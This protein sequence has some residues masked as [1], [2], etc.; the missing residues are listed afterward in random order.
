MSLGESHQEI[1]G[2]VRIGTSE[3][4]GAHYLAKRLPAMVAAYPDLEVEL[5][6]LPRNYSLGMREVDIA[7]TMDR[8]DTGDIRFKKLT[9]YALGIYGAAAYFKDRPRPLSV[10]DLSSHR[11][12]G[13][14]MDLLFT[15]EL[16]LLTFGGQAITPWYRTTSVSAQLEAVIGGSV[17]AVL[18]CYMAL[19]RGGLERLLP[20][21]VSIERTYWISVHG[22]QADSPRIRALMQQIERHVHLDRLLFLPVSAGAKGEPAAVAQT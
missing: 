13:Y 2:R 9:S 6:A 5:V 12:C 3:G 21:D 20:D 4:F 17:I 14:I 1:T 18:P 19:Q 15:T 16:D 8:P 10:A 22:D 7:I 11:W